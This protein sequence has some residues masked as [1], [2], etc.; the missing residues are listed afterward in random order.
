MWFR[1]PYDVSRTGPWGGSSTGNGPYECCQRVM[2][3]RVMT[4]AW[5]FIMHLGKVIIGGTVKK[6]SK[7]KW[8]EILAMP[9]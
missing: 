5:P 4:F 8:D 9:T 1:G 2:V 3:D 6:D 7:D